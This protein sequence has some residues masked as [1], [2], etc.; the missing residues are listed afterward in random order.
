MGFLFLSLHCI[1][2]GSV[3]RIHANRLFWLQ[4]DLQ[5]VSPRAHCSVFPLKFIFV[6]QRKTKAAAK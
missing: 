4:N 6:Q 1:L 2:M 5:A 3:F